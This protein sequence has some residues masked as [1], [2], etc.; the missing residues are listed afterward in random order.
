[1]CAI[2]A[3]GALRPGAFTV[4]TFDGCWRPLWAQRAGGREMALNDKDASRVIVRVI[5]SLR[6][7]AFGGII[8]YK[9]RVLPD[10]RRN[11]NDE[12]HTPG[13]R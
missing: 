1:L 10:G 4:R 6:R 3:A 2:R 7:V 8:H 13:G 9:Q 11:G 12:R 5:C